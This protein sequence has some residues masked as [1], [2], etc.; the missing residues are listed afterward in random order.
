MEAQYTQFVTLRLKNEEFKF[1]LEFVT[2]S[3]LLRNI[4]KIPKPCIDERLIHL[5]NVRSKLEGNKDAGEGGGGESKCVDEALKHCGI[6][7]VRTVNNGFDTG[8]EDEDEDG[9]EKHLTKCIVPNATCED[10]NL[11]I[12][13]LEMNKE[14]NIDYFNPNEL[15]EGREWE[16]TPIHDKKKYYKAI[17]EEN[18]EYFE[19]L[20]ESGNRTHMLN[21]ANYM[22]INMLVLGICSWIASQLTDKTTE[23]MQDYLGFEHNITEE[24]MRTLSKE[25]LAERNK[26]YFTP[27]ELEKINKKFDWVEAIKNN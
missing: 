18:K 26:N 6:D 22:G 14:K 13:F 11:I 23:A 24:E 27:E 12:K 4:Y 1:P 19:K 16:P 25:E 5:R 15:K 17:G 3:S 7:S 20:D 8:S 2:F 9:D 10:L 21:L